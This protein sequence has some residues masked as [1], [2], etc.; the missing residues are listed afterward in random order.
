M[1]FQSLLDHTVDVQVQVGTVAGSLG[2]KTPVYSTSAASVPCYR[3]TIGGGEFRTP[4]KYDERTTHIFYLTTQTPDLFVAGATCRLIMDSET[5]N[6]IRVENPRFH[7]LEIQAEW[8]R[9]GNN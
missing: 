5:Y 1:S 8:V 4:S 9:R 3:E 2:R 6:V 7:H